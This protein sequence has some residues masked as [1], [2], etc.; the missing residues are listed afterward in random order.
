MV[1]ASGFRAGTVV[2]QV[3]ATFVYRQNHRLARVGQFSLQH[4]VAAV[5]QFRVEPVH[6]WMAAALKLVLGAVPTVLAG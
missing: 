3:T 4:G 1:A 5:L 6:Q 2:F